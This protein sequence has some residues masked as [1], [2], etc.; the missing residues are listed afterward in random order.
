MKAKAVSLYEF[1]GLNKVPLRRL[2]PAILL[3]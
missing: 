2:P 1:D 3:Q